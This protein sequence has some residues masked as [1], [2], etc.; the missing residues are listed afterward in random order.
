MDT[1]VSKKPGTT[2][3]FKRITAFVRFLFLTGLRV[4]EALAVEWRD[5]E[6]DRIHVRAAVAKTAIPRRGRRSSRPKSTSLR[7][8]ANELQLRAV[9]R[10]QWAYVSA[11][12][13]REGE[14][15]ALCRSV[16]PPTR[17][18]HE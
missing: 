5:V 14:V 2:P 1:V 17:G 13:Q 10:R 6:D 15:G 4:S 8:A 9:R 11:S 16:E 7:T 12:S 18:A 3:K